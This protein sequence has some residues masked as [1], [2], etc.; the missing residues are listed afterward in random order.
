MSR[1]LPVDIVESADRAITKASQ[2]W[3]ENRPKAPEAFGEEIDRAIKLIAV[4]PEIGARALNVS[5]S[6]VRRVHLARIH[7]HLYYRVTVATSPRIEIL[8]L[9]HT[10][11]E[12]PPNL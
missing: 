8:A 10:S 9:W 2:W 11:R 12:G 6:G 5:L 3:F 4:E 1:R 7:Y